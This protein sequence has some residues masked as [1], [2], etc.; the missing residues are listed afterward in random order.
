MTHRLTQGTSEK[1]NG[2]GIQRE[3]G[4][5]Y[6]EENLSPNVRIDKIAKRLSPALVLDCLSLNL[7]PWSWCIFM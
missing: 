1:G 7:A 6:V 4:S 3:R 2:T 5:V